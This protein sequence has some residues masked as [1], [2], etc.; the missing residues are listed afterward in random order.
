MPRT[1]ALGAL[2]AFVV[3]AALFGTQRRLEGPLLYDD[4]AAVM[5]NPVVIGQVPLAQVWLVDFWGEHELVLPS[6][7]K[8]F[9]PLVTLTY[10]CASL[11]SRQLRVRLNLRLV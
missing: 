6:S 3:G 9:R 5:R 2:V 7:H 8:S 1:A 10:R 11:S 4:K